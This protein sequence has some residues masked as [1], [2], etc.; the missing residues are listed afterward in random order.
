[1]PFGDHDVAGHGTLYATQV[2]RLVD[3]KQI[4]R[5]AQDD[6]AVSMTAV[7][8]RQTLLRLQP[9]CVLWPSCA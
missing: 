6:N 1:M 9:C 8:R 7:L 4:L 3:Q 2:E 5:F